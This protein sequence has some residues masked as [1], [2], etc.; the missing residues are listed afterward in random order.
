MKICPACQ[1]CY[2]D[3]ET[4]CSQPEH[5]PLKNGRAGSRVIAGNYRLERWLGTGAMGSVYQGTQLD[6][7]QLRALKMLKPGYANKDPQAIERLRN[8]FQTGDL[9]GHQNIV[10]VYDYIELEDGEACIAMEFIEG[11]SLRDYM[12][13]P[14]KSP[15]PVDEAVRIAFQAAEGIDALHK[16]GV[17]HRDLKPENIML[18]KDEQGQQLVKVVDFDL[19]KPFKA[20]APARFNSF[21][22]MREF[23]GTMLYTSP[24][25][26][27]G[28][29]LDERSDIYSL[30]IILYEMLAGR[31][32]F[33]GN[34]S[35]VEQKHLGELPAPLLTRRADAPPALAQLVKDTLQK[36][37]KRR[38]QSAK[39]FAHILKNITRSLDGGRAGSSPIPGEKRERIA[40]S[41]QAAEAP[42]KVRVAPQELPGPPDL[43]PPGVKVND[44][45][46][47]RARVKPTA[48]QPLDSYI[49]I[50]TMT[51]STGRN[52][53]P[54]E[55]V[56]RHKSSTSR[57]LDTKK[58]LLVLGTVALLAI[59]LT[60]S[61]FVYPNYKVKQF[62]LHLD[63][64]LAHLEKGENEKAI[65]EFT[66]AIGWDETQSMPYYHRGV[67]HY[68]RGN[69]D[70]ALKDYTEV[71]RL[72]PEYALAY[73]N[74]A[75][76]YLVKGEYEKAIEDYTRLIRFAPDANSYK[77]RADAH[78]KNRAYTQAISD[79]TEVLKLDPNNVAALLGRADAY[80]NRG[81]KGDRALASAD[82]N[83]ANQ[84]RRRKP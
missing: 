25:N 16:K 47:L 23:V 38:P 81:G 24:E 42:P 72:A 17:L 51:S 56:N 26:C 50:P 63:Q 49:Q 48:E 32:P 62:Q 68:K 12:R 5:G 11:E 19:A 30:G 39:D 31:P 52:R 41:A 80:T 76:I 69:H 70:A 77:L 55:V 29:D 64:G 1:R 18:T 27:R 78:F 67:A 20:A 54:L 7:G 22:P 40:Q 71:I 2:E 3:E 14:G 66:E 53:R 83:R 33:S 75:T 82:Q 10:R 8:E 9:V 45:K 61:C 74:R 84:L 13:R 73:Q 28:E 35:E 79:Y 36:D 37:P 58:L 21:N 46:R 60:G 34:S 65:A 6:S 43:K 59:A 15:L 57:P 4:S 44:S